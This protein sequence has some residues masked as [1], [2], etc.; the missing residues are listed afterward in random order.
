[1]LR[2]VARVAEC[3]IGASFIISKAAAGRELEEMI[4]AKHRRWPPPRLAWSKDYLRL[5]RTLESS[6]V[7]TGD[8]L[9]AAASTLRDGIRCLDRKGKDKTPTD[10]NYH[11]KKRK[12]SQQW[13]ELEQDFIVPKSSCRKAAP[14]KLPLRP[15]LSKE[16]EDLLKMYPLPDRRAFEEWGGLVTK[17][18]EDEGG[19]LT[20]E[21]G[22][23]YKDASAH[24]WRVTIECA[25]PAGQL[26]TPDEVYTM[27][28]ELRMTLMKLRV[29]PGRVVAKCN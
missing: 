23:T 19:Y 6:G 10:P 16:C 22:R 14:A 20:T 13:S 28:A 11:C 5:D 9:Q 12:Q 15:A 17:H 2:I 29:R 21:L 25:I 1:M 26:T 27:P 4:A 3:P 8:V 24:A 7:G 18:L